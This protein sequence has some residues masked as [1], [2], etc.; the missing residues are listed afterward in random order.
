[1]RLLQNRRSEGRWEVLI[2]SLADSKDTHADNAQV[3]GLAIVL[4][5]ESH[6][7]FCF[8]I[9]FCQ[10]VHCFSPLTNSITVIFV[11]S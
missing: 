9:L 1:M 10:N 8:F 4:R 7:K 6:A 11:S 5:A 2:I 3:T